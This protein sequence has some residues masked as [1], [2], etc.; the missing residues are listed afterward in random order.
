[1]FIARLIV[2]HPVTFIALGSPGVVG[3]VPEDCGGNGEPSAF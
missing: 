1:M 2:R 3:V